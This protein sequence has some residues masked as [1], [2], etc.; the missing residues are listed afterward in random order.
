MCVSVSVPVSVSVSVSVSVPVPLSVSMPVSV[1]CLCLCLCLCLFRGECRTW[2][3]KRETEKVKDF[4]SHWRK[5]CDQRALV[6]KH[7]LD[8]DTL[9]QGPS[10]LYVR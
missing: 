4:L 8:Q 5:M 6:R 9:D 2:F 7:T 1:P 10:K 3:Q